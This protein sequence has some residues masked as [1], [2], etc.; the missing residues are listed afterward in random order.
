MAKTKTQ[1]VCQSCGASSP[2]W[3]GQCVDCQQWN[4][5]IEE[6]IEAAQT[7]AMASY[8]GVESLE[9]VTLDQVSVREYE[10]I[11]LGM[12]ELDRVMG[13]GLVQGSVTLIGGDPGIGKSS[14][15]L[16]VFAYL[17][18]HYS[19]LYVS[20]E[21]SL[22][23]I[24]LRAR[25]MGLS[26]KNFHL[27]ADTHVRAIMDG[28]KKHR[29]KMVVIDSIQTMQVEELTGA[30]GGVTQVRESAALLTRM[31]KQNNVAVFLVGH[32]T[33][34]GEV[35]GPRVL[36]HIVDTVIYLEG[37]Q[38]GRFR[39]LRALKNRF[40]PVNELGVFAMTDKGLKEVKNP[41]A[42]FLSRNEILP[43]SCVVNI[44]E[45]TRPMLL[46]VQALVDDNHFGA[47]KRLAIGYDL[48][49]L[50]ML[51]AILHKHG[52]VEIGQSDV[53]VNVVGGVKISET[54]ADLGMMLAILSSFKNKVL[55]QDLVV[56][57]E[58]GLSGEIRP[59]PYGPE[60]LAEAAKHGFKQAIISKANF[61]KEAAS[62]I[63]LQ[64]VNNVR[65]LIALI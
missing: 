55:P 54:S 56:F 41:S 1:Y 25:R 15:L 37:Q 26:T 9:W 19:V 49:R 35:A 29:P 59:V 64:V 62:K 45:G 7:K 10:R 40:G 48:N 22:D 47:P 12:E 8:A 33:K 65:E 42:I 44:W 36:E 43:G 34:S 27:V 2:K 17:S 3:V 28:I 30:P 58:V 52:G 57:G 39:L 13:G 18:Q 46:E 5:L 4:T 31:A 24:A 53:F 50:N 23:Q 51:L 63:K 21:E 61:N 16:Q 38:D 20:G 32:V 60:R 14:L 6:R 11:S